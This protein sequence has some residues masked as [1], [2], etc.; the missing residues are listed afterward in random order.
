METQPKTGPKRS[1]LLLDAIARAKE[2]THEQ[3]RSQTEKSLIKNKKS[4][5]RAWDNYYNK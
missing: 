3:S 2:I 1:Q 5:D 4:Y